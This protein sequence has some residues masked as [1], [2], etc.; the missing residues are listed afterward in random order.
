MTLGSGHAPDALSSGDVPFNNPPGSIVLVYVVSLS[1]PSFLTRTCAS[2]VVPAGG[3][4]P[5]T[6]VL[7][8]KGPLFTEFVF[9]PRSYVHHVNHLTLKRPSLDLP[10]YVPLR[11][12][13]TSRHPGAPQFQD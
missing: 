12:R 4:L 2:G 9:A 8:R 13:R 3:F 5:G 1:P 11:F 10:R 6:S 7:C